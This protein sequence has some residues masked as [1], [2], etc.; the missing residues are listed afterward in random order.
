M[1]CTLYQQA[2]FRRASGAEFRPG[3]LTLSEELAQACDLRPGERVLDLGCGVGSTASYL[4][5]RWELQ[6]TGLDA[7]PEFVAEARS[8]DRQV[9]WAVGRA[10]A[11]PFPDGHFDAVFAECFL[12]G[13]DDPVPALRE[14]KRVLRPGGRLAVSDMYLREPSAASPLVQA[15]AAT[16]LCG[17]LGKD[18]TL[19]LIQESGFRLDLWRDCSGTLKGLMAALIM[20]YGSAAAFWEAAT[21]AGEGDRCAPARAARELTEPEGAPASH[22]SW[23]AARP[24]YY[25]LVAHTDRLAAGVTALSTPS[26]DSANTPSSGRRSEGDDG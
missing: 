24:G 21:A 23:P 13:L 18:A 11:V 2:A 12:S 15:P 7:S 22:D 16:Y 19:E 25:L 3:G 4:S 6:V 5:R 20:E 14:V 1:N 26:G 10:E 9:D 17:A 8:R